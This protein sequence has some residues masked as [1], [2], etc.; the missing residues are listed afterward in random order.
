MEI[1]SMQTAPSTT[2]MPK[3]NWAVVGKYHRV[4]LALN[5]EKVVF[6]RLKWVRNDSKVPDYIKVHST[7]LPWALTVAELK[8]H[9]KFWGVIIME[10]QRHPMFDKYHKKGG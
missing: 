8:M 3:W 9:L 7:E 4:Y 6:T 1:P 10:G 5:A 2:E